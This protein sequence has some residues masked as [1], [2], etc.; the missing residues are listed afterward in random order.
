MFGLLNL[1]RVEKFIRTEFDAQMPVS[2]S[3]RCRGCF[4]YY[5]MAFYLV[6]IFKK[7]PS[8]LEMVPFVKFSSNF[9]YN[10]EKIYMIA[11]LNSDYF[12]P[13]INT[14]IVSGRS[15]RR[16]NNDGNVVSS[17]SEQSEK[18]LLSDTYLP[19][20]SNSDFRMLERLYKYMDIPK[21]SLY[22]SNFVCFNDA[23]LLY[24]DRKPFNINK[25]EVADTYI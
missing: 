14:M 11:H 3:M 13:R 9:N 7:A 22:T 23:V 15:G 12:W 25:V 19:I 5:A 1:W 16:I 20:D 17:T 8:G 10:V 4:H 21:Y 24:M 2:R 6:M 18:T